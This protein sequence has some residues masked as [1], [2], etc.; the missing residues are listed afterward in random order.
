[1][2]TEWCECSVKDIIEK[3]E[4]KIIPK[5]LRKLSLLEILRQSTVAV[6]FI[7]SKE[8]HMIHRN[9]RPSNFLIACIDP[10][11]DSFIVK[12]TD[13]QGSKTLIDNQNLSYAGREKDGWMAPEILQMKQPNVEQKGETSLDCFL[14]GLY[15]YY[16]LSVGKHPFGEG[17]D[18]QIAGIL[19]SQNKVYQDGWLGG[20]GWN[21]IHH[22]TEVRV[23]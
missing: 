2:A 19:D 12:L 20:S 22:L 5:I 4:L 9:L 8:I 10:N 11:N 7:H 1:M 18:N 6:S 13:F 21:P 17:P 16:V 15:Y 23:C 3:M 14:L